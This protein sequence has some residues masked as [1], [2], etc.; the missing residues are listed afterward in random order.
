ME[1]GLS[2]EVLFGVLVLPAVLAAA[3]IFFKGA[4][5]A[6]ALPANTHITL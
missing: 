4:R 5:P 1:A 3:A 6:T 2:F